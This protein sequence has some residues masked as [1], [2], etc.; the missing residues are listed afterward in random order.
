MK[1]TV[2]SRVARSIAF[3]AVALTVVA[4]VF[5]GVDVGIGTA[6][7]GAIAVADF[8][9][10]RFAG[11]VLFRGSMRDKALIG[12]LLALKLG[13]LGALLFILIV[14]LGVHAGGLVL[15]LGSLALGILVGSSGALRSRNA[16]GS[17][18]HAPLRAPRTP[19]ET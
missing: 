14:L 1:P 9:L 8:A 6:I 15:G 13:A 3:F 7:G 4:F 18:G 16:T 11:S 12:A 10:M 5:F 17:D 2:E 19:G